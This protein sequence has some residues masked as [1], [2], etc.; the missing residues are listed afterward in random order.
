MDHI[1]QVA[2]RL[3]GL[4]DALDLTVEQI[5]ESCGISPQLYAEYE[6]G[7]KDIP[8]SFL[9]RISAM[10][11]VE[12]TALMFGEEPKMASYFVTRAG[13]GVKIERTKA[14]SYQDMAAGFA[15]RKMAPFI[16]TIEP[17]SAEK[18]ITLNS[19]QGQEF[20]LVIEGCMQ[21]VVDGKS[22]ILNPGDTIMFDA[23]RPHGMKVVGDQPVKFLAIIS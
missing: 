4:R 15:H 23:S 21:I 7:Q 1:Q 9:H 20:N 16:V 12:L 3:R 2:Y 8:V 18:E 6:N 10:Y 13:Q 14:Y 22:M 5:A 19:H 11:G 17:A